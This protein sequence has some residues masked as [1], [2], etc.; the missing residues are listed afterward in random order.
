LSSE[1]D[2]ASLPYR[3]CAGIALFNP[4]GLVWVGRR[5][6]GPQEAEGI[7]QWWQMPQGGIDEGE[8]PVTAARRELTEETGVTSASYLGEMD[9][10]TYDLPDELI[11]KAWK[12][13]YRGQR[14]KWVAFGFDGDEAEIDVLD[15]G[16]GHKP[17]FSEWRWE[18]LEALPELV[19]PFKRPTYE[20]VAREFA[21]FAKSDG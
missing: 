8:D 14:M 9:W 12:G 7:G 21:R 16:E 15:P 13:R 4:E 1:A 2:P 6:D 5:I 17:E 3:P 18:R 20:A 19:V 10:L 11:G